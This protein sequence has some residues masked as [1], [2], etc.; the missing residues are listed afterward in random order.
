[1]HPEKPRLSA[2]Q[3]I[4]YDIVK[5]YIAAF[6]V[7]PT[8]QEIANQTDGELNKTEVRTYL[9]DVMRKGYLKRKYPNV[10]GAERNIALVK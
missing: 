5:Q 2:N 1:M 4:V 7:A 9:M 10:K 6:H 3:K 8:L